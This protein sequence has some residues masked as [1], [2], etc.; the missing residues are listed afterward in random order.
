MTKSAKTRTTNSIDRIANQILNLRLNG[1]EK[2]SQRKVAETGGFNRDTVRVHWIAA[3]RLA[4]EKAN[5][6]SELLNKIEKTKK[7]M[8]TL[9]R[10]EERTEETTKTKVDTIVREIQI[11]KDFSRFKFQSGN[12]NIKNSNVEHKMDS[13][14]RNIEQ[15]IPLVYQPIIVNENYEIQEGQHRFHALK[16]LSKEYEDIYIEYIVTEGLTLENIQD[17]Q[18][19]KVWSAED[20]LDSH[21]SNDKQDY[22][23]YKNFR[24]QYKKPKGYY[25]DREVLVKILTDTKQS[26]TPAIWNTGKLQIDTVHLT[27]AHI[28]MSYIKDFE[29]NGYTHGWT[30]G[31]RR[32]FYEVMVDFFRYNDNKGTTYDHQRMIKCLHGKMGGIGAQGK[33]HFKKTIAELYNKKLKPGQ[34]G[35]INIE[36]M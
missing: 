6:T 36:T 3:L 26:A 32:R 20:F 23:V 13:I 16:N 2:F 9:E 28:W 30:Q 33:D 17:M 8:E 24:D 14:R 35:H 22:I 21:I 31:P 5:E 1:I 10:T 12:R 34:P 25:A 19:G 11:T 27:T 29:D 4:E 18:G 7:E 15:G